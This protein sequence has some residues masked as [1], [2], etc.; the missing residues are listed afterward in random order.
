MHAPA[1]ASNRMRKKNETLIRPLSHVLFI[2]YLL[3]LYS[4]S[5]EGL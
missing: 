2:I 3:M 4:T 5:A 1:V